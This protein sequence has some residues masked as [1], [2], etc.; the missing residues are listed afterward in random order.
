MSS[1]SCD[2]KL[3][4]DHP[5]PD[6]SDAQRPEKRICFICG[7]YTTSIINIHEPRCGP[8]MIDVISEKYQMR[9][10]NDDKFVCYDCNNWLV[11]W[12]SMR[13]KNNDDSNHEST[14]ST[15]SATIATNKTNGKLI[16]WFLFLSMSC[17]H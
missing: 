12:Y 6:Q 13:K 17:A 3:S 16:E 9:P 1:N 15:I 14:S 11:N 2:E 5:S 10:L 4:T 8:N 7:S